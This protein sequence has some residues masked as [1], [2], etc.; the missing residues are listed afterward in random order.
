MGDSISIA[1]CA[2]LLATTMFKYFF[3]CWSAQELKEAVRFP[4]II[5]IWYSKFIVNI[6]RYELNYF[7]I[8]HSATSSHRGC[9]TARG[10]ACRSATASCSQSWWLWPRN[11]GQSRSLDS[12]QLSRGNSSLWWVT[13]HEIVPFPMILM[14]T[15]TKC[16]EF[17]NYYIIWCNNEIW[18]IL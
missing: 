11:H 5:V 17:N 14:K 1:K 7:I 8:Q 10:W 4:C 16:F 18:C 3:Y 9:T 15:D 2:T 6:S 12:S 13:T